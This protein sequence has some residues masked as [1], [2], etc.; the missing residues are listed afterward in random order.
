MKLQ[1]SMTV[2]IGKKPVKLSEVKASDKVAGPGEQPATVNAI[3]KS[4]QRC[5]L[6]PV[7]DEV[8]GCDRNTV[9]GTT[10]GPTMLRRLVEGSAINTVDG[11][12]AK[13]IIQYTKNEVDV[14]ELRTD[15]PIYVSGVEVH[16]S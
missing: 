14:V 16:P 13:G 5:W 15:Q 3:A 11:A 8:L 12:I 7:G 10:A 1:A 4:K 9:V 2:M 6:L